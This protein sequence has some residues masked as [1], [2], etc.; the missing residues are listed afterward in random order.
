MTE[1][2]QLP[3]L[4]AKAKAKHKL[5]VKPSRKKTKEYKVS[6][7]GKHQIRDELRLEAQTN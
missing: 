5:I 7:I 2:L 6:H 3:L 1:L 4:S